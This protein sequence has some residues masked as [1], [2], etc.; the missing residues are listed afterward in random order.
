MDKKMRSLPDL[1]ATGSSRPVRPG[2]ATLAERIRPVPAVS[3]AVAIL[4]A[5]GRSA[6]PLGVKALADQ[7][8]IVPSTCLHILRV[9]VAEQLVRIDPSTR[10]YSLG[11]GLATLARAALARDPFP[12]LAQP[13]LDRL[14][15]RWKVTAIGVEIVALE[16]MLVLAI[17]RSEAPFRLHVDVG[18]RFPALISATGRLVAA[19]TQ[20]PP[21]ELEARFR[22]L[23]WQKAPGYRRWLGQV[24]EVRERGYSLDEGDYI[25]GVR[26]V[27]VPVFNAGGL[28]SHA[29]VAAEMGESNSARARRGLID[30]LLVQARALSGAL[31]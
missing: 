1:A 26:L 19:F 12:A 30:D 2:P 22:K 3:R 27:A 31:A 18:S 9:L 25:A 17:S 13:A 29:L 14:S 23:R 8:D 16:H 24:A 10:R 28:L 6:E 5:L 4:R 21:G 15:Q 7:L 11:N 20:W